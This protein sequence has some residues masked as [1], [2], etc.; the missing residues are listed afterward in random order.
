MAVQFTSQ[1]QTHQLIFMVISCRPH[2]TWSFV[3]LAP[4]TGG[5]KRS[6]FM[7]L[8]TLIFRAKLWTIPASYK[9]ILYCRRQPAKSSRSPLFFPIGNSTPQRQWRSTSLHVVRRYARPQHPR[10]PGEGN[11]PFAHNSFLS[12]FT[13]MFFLHSFHPCC[14][15]NFLHHLLF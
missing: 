5:L 7:P 10:L 14:C 3:S 1:T 6:H 2:S 11:I 4:D 15:F 13:F 9:S 8:Y 12:V